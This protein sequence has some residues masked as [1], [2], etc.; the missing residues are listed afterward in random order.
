MV[1]AVVV[2]MDVDVG[3]DVGMGVGMDV[4]VA[5]GRGCGQWTWV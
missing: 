2:G 5:S 4:N 3:M 1:G